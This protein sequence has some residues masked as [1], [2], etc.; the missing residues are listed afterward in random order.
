M[1]RVFRSLLIVLFAAVLVLSGAALW[2]LHAP[3]PLR[4]QP[5]NQVATLKLNTAQRPAASLKQ[6]LP[7][8]LTCPCFGC[9]HGFVSRQARLIKAG[10][11]E[12]LPSTS[13]R[14]LLSMLV[15]GEGEKRSN[16][17]RWSKAGPFRRF[18]KRY[19]KQSN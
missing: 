2:W 18:A 7:A 3:M 17:S 5:G 15:R 1:R 12:L 19:K 13:P 8:A 9:R 6:W 11:Y 14:K 10:S 4:L 16:I